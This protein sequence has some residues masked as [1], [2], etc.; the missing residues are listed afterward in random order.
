MQGVALVSGLVKVF[1]HAVHGVHHLKQSH[2]IKHKE[3][4]STRTDSS[5][6]KLIVGLVLCK[7]Q[8][9]HARYFY[10]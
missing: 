2:C 10:C 4:P 5:L 7:V 9:E 8:K 6:P 3:N 1:C